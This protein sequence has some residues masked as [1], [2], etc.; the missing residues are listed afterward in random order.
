MGEFGADLASSVAIY[1]WQ[2]DP[3]NWLAITLSVLIVTCPCALSLATPTAVTAATGKLIQSGLL[4]TRGHALET[5]AKASHVVFDKTG[6]LT[7]GLLT[8]LETSIRR[9]HDKEQCLS[10]AAALEV[11]SEHPIA[12]AIRHGLDDNNLQAR[13][14]KNIPGSGISG[15]IE[16]E[17][18]WIGTPNFVE[19]ASG[20]HADVDALQK[21]RVSG[22]TV[23]AL[24][25]RESV[26]ALFAFGDELRDDAVSAIMDLKSAGKKIVLLSGDHVVVAKAVADKLGID[27]VHGDFLPKDKLAYVKRLQKQGAI[28]VM[29]G[30]GIND[31]PV[32]AAAQVSIA[33]GS[34]TQ[35]AAAGADMLLLSDRL[36][37]ISDG[38]YMV[39]RILWVIR[40]NVSWVI[41][42]NFLALPF[43]SMGFVAPWMAALGMSA[44]SLIV[45]A[46]AL[47]LLRDKRN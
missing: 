7:Y 2:H 1:W 6:T 13:D 32:L 10:I 9:G 41:G 11:G 4:A 46:N 20:H 27:D 31:A 36:S 24:A 29:V 43:A 12:R 33:M 8:L 3:E 42:Y 35:L 15:M 16:G 5:L 17:D 30:D 40:K 25:N 44:S 39:Q 45:V 22:N 14:I 37:G 21:L 23:I 19:M 47:R 34:G 18:Y 28:V 26:F 38:L